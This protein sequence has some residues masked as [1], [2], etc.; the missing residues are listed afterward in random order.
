MRRLRRIL[1]LSLVLLAAAC[2]PAATR[3]QAPDD[4]PLVAEARAFMEAYGRDL[5]AGNREGIAARYD[6]GGPYIMFNGEREMVPWEQLAAQYRTTWRQPA[7]FEW[8][9]LVFLP[10]GPD[11]VVVNGHFFWTRP[12]GAEPTRLRYTALLV[13]QEGELRIRL[14]DESVAPLEPAPPA[15]PPATP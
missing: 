5:A 3:A 7:A 14:E 10:A 9:D 11:A 2:A 4:A 8:R 13:R 15:A 12:G 6:R 1:P